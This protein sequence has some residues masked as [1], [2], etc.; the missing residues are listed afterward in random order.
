MCQSY[1]HLLLNMF[2]KSKFLRLS[3][4]KWHNYEHKLLMVCDLLSKYDTR[5]A[6]QLNISAVNCIQNEKQ[7]VCQNEK[8]N[9]G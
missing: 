9:L 3:P 4:P 2:Y 7:N 1:T 5:V 6:Y 8:L